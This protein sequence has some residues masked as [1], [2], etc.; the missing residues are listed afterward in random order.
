M[1]FLQPENIML[2]DRSVPLPRIKLIDFGLAH[3]IEPGADFKNIF[4]TPEFVGKIFFSLT[5]GVFLRS[6][7]FVV[8]LYGVCKVMFAPSIFSSGDSELW[9]ARTGGRHVVRASNNV[10]PSRLPHNKPLCITLDLSFAVF[11]GASESSPI[12]CE[13]VSQCIAGD[14]LQLVLVSVWISALL[15]QVERPLTFPWWNKTRNSGKY[16]SSRLW[17]WWRVFQQYQWAG[18]ELHQAATGKGHEV[19]QWKTAEGQ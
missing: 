8:W 12:Y 16:Y 7:P 17:L 5:L 4:G 6:N 1:S 15:F 18:Q 3:K 13:F 14:C 9:A 19:K 10:W 11:T 2:L